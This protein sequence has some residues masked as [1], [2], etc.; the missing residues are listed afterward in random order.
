MFFCFLCLIK[1]YNYKKF[2]VYTS[3]LGVS[4]MFELKI[5]RVAEATLSYRPINPFGGF[6]AFP[7]QTLPFGR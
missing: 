5:K 1:L 6:G 4:S 3:S 7:F 2:I